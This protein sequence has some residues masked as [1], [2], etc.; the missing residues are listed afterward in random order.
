MDLAR[1]HAFAG[2]TEEAVREAKAAYREIEA[3]DKSDA[4]FARDMF[5]QLYVM[6][7]QREE[8]LA[9]LRGLMTGFSVRGPQEIRHDPLWSRL[10]DDPRFE[11]IL[12]SAKPL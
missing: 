7:G 8:A 10:K 3:V 1:S 6:L 5:G 2:R 4:I 12:Q 11:E 9:E